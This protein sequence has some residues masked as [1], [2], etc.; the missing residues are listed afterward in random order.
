MF[1]II[2]PLKYCY[3]LSA[4]HIIQ[5]QFTFF[6]LWKIVLSQLAKDTDDRKHYVL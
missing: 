3:I 5:L 6:L 2:F 1:V 4:W